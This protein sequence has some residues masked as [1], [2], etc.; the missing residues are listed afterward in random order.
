MGEWSEYFEDHPEM[1]ES[2]YING[3]FDPH[4]AAEA[5]AIA[6]RREREQA[7]LNATVSRLI[8]EG[9]ERAKSKAAKR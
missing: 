6:G 1:D 7:A 4:A 3:R 5:R 8:R 2:N 9:K